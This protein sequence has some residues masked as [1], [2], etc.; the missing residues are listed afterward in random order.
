MAGL[1]NELLSLGANRE[2]KKTVF[3]L[4]TRYLQVIEA[5]FF[6]IDD[7]LLPKLPANYEKR[8]EFVLL[9]GFYD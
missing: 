1:V 5:A 2:F 7:N 8:L 3:K 4:W 9:K 6:S